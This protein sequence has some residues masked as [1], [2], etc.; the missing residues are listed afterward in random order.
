MKKFF[1]TILIICFV[2]SLTACKK[3]N[4]VENS[5]VSFDPDE[6]IS[7]S[8]E[9]TQEQW[10]AIFTFEN[11]VNFT[12]IVIAHRP[13]GNNYIAATNYYDNLNGNFMLHEQ[14]FEENGD[15]KRENYFITEDDTEY[16]I[17]DAFRGSFQKYTDSNRLRSN[18]LVRIVHQYGEYTDYTYDTEKG[19][20]TNEAL[21]TSGEAR[22]YFELYFSEGQLSKAVC[23]PKRTEGQYIE[24][25]Y[26][27]FGDVSFTLPEI[28]VLETVTEEE[29]SVTVEMFKDNQVDLQS[30]LYLTVK[31]DTTAEFEYTATFTTEHYIDGEWVSDTSSGGNNFSINALKS[32]EATTVEYPF[33]EYTTRYDYYESEKLRIMCAFE[34]PY[35]YTDRGTHRI[36]TEEFTI[37]DHFSHSFNEIEITTEKEEYT[38]SDEIN[39]II[40][41]NS[42]YMH[43]YNSIFVLE[44]FENGDWHESQ[45]NSD[46]TPSKQKMR[47]DKS[48]CI[49]DLSKC[50]DKGKEKYRLRVAF[51]GNGDA[52]VYLYTNEFSVIEEETEE[53]LGDDIIKAE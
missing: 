7:Q 13:T 47:V 28:P 4:L 5:Y 33:L 21:L 26:K 22:E 19:C 31:I 23:D 50:L 43:E 17:T 29:I 30:H 32:N 2:F 6:I 52:E 40:V 34:L 51:K 9:I 3:D 10:N 35:E 39:F 37:Y 14:T 53:N 25:I 11:F 15:L 49:Y 1:C 41:N 18:F 12:E 44:H 8:E 20:Y 45:V 48:Y 42:D 36:Y 46:N 38:F 16:M 24:Y 27:D